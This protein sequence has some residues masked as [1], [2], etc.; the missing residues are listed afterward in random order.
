MHDPLPSIRGF[1]RLEELLKP[2]EL[3]YYSR[4]KVGLTFLNLAFKEIWQDP[5]NTE[6]CEAVSRVLVGERDCAACTI[7]TNPPQNTEPTEAV[8]VAGVHK[9]VAAV[10]VQGRAIGYVCGPQQPSPSLYAR[11]LTLL[12][13]DLQQW[14]EQHRNTVVDRETVLQ[15]VGSTARRLSRR[16]A[17]ERRLWILRDTRTRF[18]AARDPEEVL[19]ITCRALEALFGV[20]DICFYVLEE[21]G[22]INLISARG[23]L[24]D[25]MPASLVPE[26][27][28]VGRVIRERV[29]YYQPDLD[30]DTDFIH[31]KLADRVRSAFT[32]PLPWFADEAPGALQAA[33]RIKDHFPLYDRQA[34]QGVAEMAGLAAVKLFLK[35]RS[36]GW[37]RNAAEETWATIGL[38]LIATPSDRP[39]EILAARSRLYRAMAEEALRVSG[40]RAACVGIMDKRHNIVRAA[41]SAGEGWTEE[42]KDKLARP[43]IRNAVSHVLEFDFPYDVSDT[44]EQDRF[45]TILPFTRSLYILPFGAKNEPVGVLSLSKADPNAFTENEKDAAK[46]LADQFGEILAALDTREDMLFK[47]LVKEMDL[48][49]LTRESIEWI[50]RAFKVRSCSLFLKASSADRVELFATTGPMPDDVHAYEHGEGLTGWVAAE[51]KSLRVRNTNDIAELDAISKGLRRKSAREKWREMIADENNVFLAVP[52]IAREQLVGVMRLK[53][54]DDLTEFTHE[55]E[56]AV[57]HVASRLAAAIDDVLVANETAEKIHQLEKEASL[58]HKIE[59]ETLQG[60][61]QIM[62]EEFRLDT[63]AVAAAIIV[64][65]S[66]PGYEARIM[67]PAGLLKGLTFDSAHAADGALG[68]LPKR[69]EPHYD[70]HVGSRTE[71]RTVLAPMN[72]RYPDSRHAIVSAATLPFRLEDKIFGVLLLCWNARQNFDERGGEHLADLGRRAVTA[73]RPSAI[74]RHIDKDLDHLVHELKRLREIGLGFAQNHDLELLMQE[75]LDVS[76]DESQLERGSI[77]FVNDT[78]STLDLKAAKKIPIEHSRQAINITPFYENSIGSDKCVFVSDVLTNELWTVADADT[79]GPQIRSTLHVPI[80]L[81]GKCIGLIVLDSSEVRDLDEKALYYLEILSHYAAVAIDFARMR[82]ELHRTIELAQP[83]AMM[84]TMLRGFLHE[85]RNRINDLFAILS[86]IT[87]TSAS[88]YMTE[89]T[90]EMRYELMRLHQVCN[91]LAHFTRTDPVSVSEEVSLNDLVERTLGSFGTRMR[92]QGVV[93]ENN[94]ETPSPVVAGNPIQLEIAFKMLIQ[95]ALEAMDQGGCLV[96]DSSR[97]SAFTRISIRDTG[98]GMDEATKAQCFEPFFTT[99]RDSGGTGLGLSVVFGIMTRHDG[100]VEIQSAPG[101]GSTFTLLFPIK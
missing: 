69:L 8:C 98:P 85:I 54:K 48:K 36:T 79:L 24:E 91:D 29:P 20:V 58:H 88:L 49:E 13:P 86:N 84:G 42:A 23:P 37:R 4:G 53:V 38:A 92:D 76:L 68:I 63:G 17:L 62:A 90:G 19:D 40:A 55:E 81:K 66:T 99:K 101:S 3:Q 35:A 26:Q 1:F 73:L 78:T 75:I 27:G 82:K 5:R 57:L 12:P 89:K 65:D 71:W 59:A 94:V 100:R 50:R 33:S 22:F 97:D 9:T 11:D 93:P 96:V 34:M 80:R 61:S 10:M 87:D 41:A 45:R 39:A 30:G 60:T 31:A 70:D 6:L 15:A 72:S 47:Q 74:R 46:R 7:Q 56:T 25:S 18:V 2:E 95:N 28:H 52:L 43:D 51:R 64:D 21:K 44:D 32:V 16:C 83:L 14:L 67:A 77:R